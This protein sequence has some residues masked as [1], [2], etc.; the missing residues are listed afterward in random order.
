VDSGQDKYERLEKLHLRI[1]E[2]DIESD[3]GRVADSAIIAR[4]CRDCG[5]E[6][7]WELWAGEHWALD[8]VRLAPPGSVYTGSPRAAPPE[9][10]P[11]ESGR[12]ERRPAA[13][14]ASEPEPEVP[15]PEAPTPE[16]PQSA[17]DAAEPDEAEPPDPHEVRMRA[18]LAQAM[19]SGAWI[20]VLQ[21]DPALAG[22]VRSRLNNS[23]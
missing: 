12:A 10:G 19:G 9:P 14:E 15:K 3:I 2:E 22:Y 7:P 16:P 1:D 11:E 20:R 4:L 6:A 17:A 5:I 18:R 21:T 8:E 13:P 23:S